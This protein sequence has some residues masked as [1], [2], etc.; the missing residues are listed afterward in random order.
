M[1][2]DKKCPVPKTSVTKTSDYS[3][4][5]LWDKVMLQ[6]W[7]LR[8]HVRC[9]LCQKTN[10]HMSRYQHGHIWPSLAIAP[11]RPLLLAGLPG[12]IQY[13]H[14]AAVCIFELDVLLFARPCE[15][16]H[17][18]TSLTSS[19]QLLQQ[20]PAC[21]VRLILIVFVTG[22]RWPYSYCFVGCIS[23]TCSI[24]LAAGS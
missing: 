19:P 20:C 13:L 7:N 21:L 14:R 4:P 12:Y 9:Y 10:E 6:G 1:N 24:L 17:R 11:Y 2:K 3:K 15:G 22:G 8:L 18:T 16:V 5:P 23:R